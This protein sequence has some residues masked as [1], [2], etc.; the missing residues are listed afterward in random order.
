MTA[1]EE[2]LYKRIKNGVGRAIADFNLIEEGDRIAVAVSGGKDSYTLLQM[3]E[4]LRRR[5]PVKYELLALTIDSG[6]PGFRADIIAAHLQATGVP[7]H[8]EKTNHFEII[9]EKRRPGSSYCSICAR[10]KRGVLYTLAQQFGCNKLALGHHLDDFIETLLLN[11]FY[12]GSLKAMAPRMLAD[13]GATV[14]IR[15]LVYVE[16]QEIIPFAQQSG[17]P[18]VCCCCPVCGTAD[19]QRQRMKKLLAELERENPS[20]KRS[21]LRALANVQPRHLL[22]RELQ[23]VCAVP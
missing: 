15:P 3:L 1:V 11:Q 14:V 22:D 6:Y 9:T 5:A 20:V 21:L 2:R 16:E 19:L 13:N 7:Y 10:L 8:V 18:V 4:A 17:F 12:V 23:Q